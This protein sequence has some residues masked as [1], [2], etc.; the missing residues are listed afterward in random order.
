MANT[1]KYNLPL[2]T[3]PSNADVP[4][5]LNALAYAVEN[6]IDIHAADAVKHITSVERSKW[7][8]GQLYKLTNDN[9]TLKDTAV[10]DM[11]LLV[12]PGE[13]AVGNGI[14]FNKPAG[15]SHG[16]VRVSTYGADVHQE[17]IR[18]TASGVH[19]RYFRQRSGTTWTFWT[20]YTRREDMNLLWNPD[21]ASTIYVAKTGND[22]T[23]DGT[24]AK[25]F[26]SVQRGLDAIPR[27][28]DK[29]YTIR[30]GPGAYD[31]EL[32][33]RGYLGGAISFILDGTDPNPEAGKTGLSIRSFTVEACTAYVLIKNVDF[34]NSSTITSDAVVH[35]KRSNHVTVNK[36][37][38]DSGTKD[39]E[40]A[41]VKADAST[42]H[43]YDNYFTNQYICVHAVMMS[44]VRIGS[45]NVHSTTK[46]TYGLWIDS[47]VVYK[48][49]SNTWINNATTP[50]FTD[51]GGYVRA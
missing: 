23:G 8:N 9:G 14:S 21:Q 19:R 50:T 39:A 40:K 6:G 29:G 35:V 42:V 49:G 44:Q 2:T 37:R 15:S 38:F 34:Y 48:A 18:R 3:Y 46:S 33:L 5:D 24:S 32:L 20:E 41:S 31:E 30:I 43:V 11:N 10:N 1:P 12:S 36:C 17:F 47:S 16:L 45:S 51:N 28:L 26:K 4:R 22:S 13:Y 7:N 27:I 25:P